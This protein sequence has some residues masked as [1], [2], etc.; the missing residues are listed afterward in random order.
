M[1]N[2]NKAYAIFY[3]KRN[4]GNCETSSQLVVCD[5]LTKLSEGLDNSFTLFYL[6]DF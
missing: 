6:L 3:E 2:T 1:F 5:F 4:K